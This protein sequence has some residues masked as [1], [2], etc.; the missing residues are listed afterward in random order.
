MFNAKDNIMKKIREALVQPTGLP[1]PKSEGNSSVF[2]PLT[3]EIEVEFAE[4]FTALE[5]KFAFCV[6]KNDLRRQFNALL[7]QSKWEKV[8]CAE[9]DICELLGEAISV[10]TNSD[11]LASCDISVTGCEFLVARTGSIVMT[12]AQKSGRNTSIY[13]P[14]HACIAFTS[15]LVYDIKDALEGIKEK[16]AG[17]IPSLITFATGP[18]RTA[19][20]EKTLVV[21]VHGPNDVFVF[22]VDDE[23]S[24]CV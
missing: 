12:A 3:Q 10:S 21:G 14:V 4:R 23:Q 24:L 20:I 9:P 19:D 16:Y 6:D 13:A 11:E 2:L 18:S 7:A 22:L 8:Y 17:N 5:G 1:F 15:Q